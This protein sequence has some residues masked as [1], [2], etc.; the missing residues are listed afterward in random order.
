LSD[1][2]Y[3]KNGV[4]MSDYPLPLQQGWVLTIIGEIT[5]VDSGIG[6]PEKYQGKKDGDFPFYKV[7]D[8]S[9]TV[10]KGGIYLTKSDNYIS[11][12]DFEALKAKLIKKDSLVFAKIESKCYT[13][14]RCFS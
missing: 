13:E 2:T 5:S 9:K 14:F 3:C 10:K 4:L 6:F 11:L 1:L 12:K 8:I 7:M